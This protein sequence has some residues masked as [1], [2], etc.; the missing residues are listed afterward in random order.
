SWEAEG[1]RGRSARGCEGG[2]PAAAGVI[3]SLGVA[4]DLTRVADR[5]EIGGDEFVERR[6]FRAGD[7]NDAVSRRCHR[8]IGNESSN[9]VRSDGLKQ[10]GRILTTFPSAR[11]SAMA[12][13]NSMNW[14][15]RMMV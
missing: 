15:E 9:V 6:S 4:H 11:E 12:R 13:R 5:L 8:H 2:S 14:V 3:S 10:A 7:F 1:A